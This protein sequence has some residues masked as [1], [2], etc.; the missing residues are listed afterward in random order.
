MRELDIHETREL[1][2]EPLANIVGLGMASMTSA[3]LAEIDTFLG[4]D[5]KKGG[6]A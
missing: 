3:K 6:A 2:D 5:P 1:G 4:Q